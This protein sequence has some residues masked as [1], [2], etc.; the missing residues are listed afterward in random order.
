[1]LP[2][3]WGAPNGAGRCGGVGTAARW[4]RDLWVAP[5]RSGLQTPPGQA[6][7]CVCVCDV[8]EPPPL[9]VLS[10]RICDSLLGTEGP[11]HVTQGGAMLA[12]RQGV[13]VLSRGRAWPCLCSPSQAKERAS[14]LTILPTSRL[15]HR[16]AAAVKEGHE[17]ASVWLCVRGQVPGPWQLLLPL[18]PAPALLGLDLWFRCI[19]ARAHPQGR[20]S[21]LGRGASKQGDK[22]QFGTTKGHL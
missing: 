10:P 16:A 7:G 6:A 11:L 18:L 14:G 21:E 4:L 22:D 17:G 12:E 20:A 3:E 2:Q 13:C 5:L 9:P 15:S 1:M 8:P 19:R